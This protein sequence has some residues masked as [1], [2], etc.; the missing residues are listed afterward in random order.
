MKKSILYF[1]LLLTL[2]TMAQSSYRGHQGHRPQGQGQPTSLTIV[3]SGNQKFWLFV[4]D[5]LQNANA[6]RSIQINNMTRDEYYIRVEFDNA[7]QDC[8]GRYIHPRELSVLRVTQ[9]GDRLSLSMAQGNY[10][11][12]LTMDLK[13]ELPMPTPPP[14]PGGGGQPHAPGFHHGMNPRDF[15]QAVDM[16]SKKPFDNDRLTTA[17]QIVASNPMTTD[18]IA[19][20]CRQFNF[21]NYRLDFAKYA[22]SYCVDKNRYFILNEVFTFESYRRELTEYIQGLD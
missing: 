6:V 21:D 10:H 11:P 8:I 5:V 14:H 7:N 2:P 1:F 20:I 3:A 19:E 13:A 12:A 17:K 16:I 4:D 18:Q 22:Y 15:E 9:Q